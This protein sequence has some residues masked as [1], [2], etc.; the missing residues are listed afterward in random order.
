MSRRI[1]ALAWALLI[2]QAGCVA[3]G[4]VSTLALPRARDIGESVFLEVQVGRLG[5]GQEIELSTD[6][7]RPLGMISPHG[8]R[9]G[10]DAG[11]Y[12]VPLPAHAVRDGRVRVR[13]RVVRAGAAPRR[14]DASEVRGLR[15]VMGR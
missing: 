7:G 14:P 4:D 10:H 12:V 9:P 6:T 5:S 2:V 8:L 15:I 1:A 11:A 13:L 3:P